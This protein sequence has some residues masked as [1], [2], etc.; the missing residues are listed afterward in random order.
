MGIALLTIALFVSARMGIYQEVLY[1]RY[2]KYPDEALFF[3]VSNIDRLL[4]CDYL[5]IIPFFQNFQHLLPLPFFFL[6][7]NNIWEHVKI[8]TA[9]EIYQLPIVPVGLPIIWVYLIGN[10]ITQYFCISSVYVLTTECSSL[11]VTLVVTLRKFTSLIFSIIYFNNP[12]T[13]YHWTGFFLVFFGTVIFTEVI[14]KITAS[15]KSQPEPLE[16][17]KTKKIVGSDKKKTK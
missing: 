13:I 10:V 3:T 14:P 12:F 1:K 15:F 17:D 2:G 16:S 4:L 11:T 7:Y 9:S 5:L 8:A 6:L